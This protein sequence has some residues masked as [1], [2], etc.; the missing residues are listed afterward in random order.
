M[1]TKRPNKAAVSQFLDINFDGLKTISENEI[2]QSPTDDI[3]AGKAYTTNNK[4]IIIKN[5]NPSECQ[6]W[7]YAD[8]PD[9]EMGDLHALAESM[10]QGQAEPILARPVDR[11][12]GI[13]YEV[14]FGHRRWR[15]AK[16]AN[17]PLKAIIQ[18]LT[19]QEAS[20]QQELENSEREDISDFS[21]SMYYQ[22]L[23]EEGV[24]K[25]ESQLAKSRGIARNTFNALMSYTR[26]PT[27]L[28]KHIQAPQNIAIRLAV[29]LATLVKD[30]KNLSI[31]IT[32]GDEISKG[33][34]TSANVEK[35]LEKLKSTQTKEPVA[36]EKK[37]IL[38]SVT[39]KPIFTFE[40]KKSGKT[41]I[42]LEKN[43]DQRINENEIID[44][45]RSYIDGK[46]EN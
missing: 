35:T 37:A 3:I 34:I 11:D 14:I 40:S 27:E 7:Q 31:L 45:I 6:P 2:R 22:R 25:N 44:L 8:R 18:P 5:I 23:L 24:Y 19:D 28:M 16:Q 39:N 33:K 46:L 32:L 29:K 36:V 4:D 12:D 38:S 1:T 21:R 17:L 15:A 26:I 9:R 42:I 30:E 43:I 10:K 13:R 20:L 41:Q